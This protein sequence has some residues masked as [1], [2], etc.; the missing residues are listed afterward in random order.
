MLAN[1]SALQEAL[2]ILPKNYEFEVPKTLHKILTLQSKVVA[3]QFPEGLLFV[4][5]I[6]S[7]IITRFTGARVIILSD[8]TYGACC[9][10]D[11]SSSK[12]GA[13]LLVHYGHSCLVPIQNVRIKVGLLC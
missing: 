4:S 6:I 3:L 9:I 8:V 13:D 11:F 5:C 7:D 12:L 2:A 1:N 10:D